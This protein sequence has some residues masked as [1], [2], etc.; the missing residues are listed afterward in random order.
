MRIE[1]DETSSGSFQMV[2]LVVINEEIFSEYVVINSYPQ[3]T[4][5]MISRNKKKK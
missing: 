4:K 5:I 3:S 1:V 2:E